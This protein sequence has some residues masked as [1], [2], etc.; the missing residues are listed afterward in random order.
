MT[1]ILLA[2]RLLGLF[3]WAEKFEAAWANRRRGATEQRSADNELAV[4]TIEAEEVAADAAPH[5]A[6][7]VG[8]RLRDGT[9]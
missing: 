7:D 3:S 8:K 6:V 2:L 5:T 4:Q 1:W 9:F